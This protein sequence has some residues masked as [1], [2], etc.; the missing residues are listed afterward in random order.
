MQHNLQ[1]AFQVQKVPA[2]NIL[3]WD[4]PETLKTSH[5]CTA[6]VIS[7]HHAHPLETAGGGWHKHEKQAGVE[8][9]QA[10]NANGL[11]RLSA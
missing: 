8:F 4:E 10:R 3:S 11:M 2:V 7:V 9:Y 5:S 1:K 6:L